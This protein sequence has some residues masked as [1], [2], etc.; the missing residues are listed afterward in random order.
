MVGFQPLNLAVIDAF[1]ILYSRLS[2]FQL[3]FEHILLLFASSFHLLTLSLDPHNVIIFLADLI[4]MIL[5]DYD[6]LLVQFLN[7]IVLGDD[8]PLKL[9]NLVLSYQVR[10]IFA[11]VIFLMDFCSYLQSLVHL[12]YLSLPLER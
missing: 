10:L 4:C 7:L 5:F 6:Y 2:L 1:V 12:F 3:I 9:L 11:F 8:Q